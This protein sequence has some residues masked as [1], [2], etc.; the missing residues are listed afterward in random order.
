MAHNH[1]GWALASVT[2]RPGFCH[3]SPCTGPSRVS[4]CLNNAPGPGKVRG[5]RPRTDSPP[6][7]GY[8]VLMPRRRHTPLPIEVWALVAGAFAV[9]LGYGV[10]APAIPQ[11]AHAFGVSNAAASGIVS[12][13]ALMRLVGA[14]LA[15]SLIHISEPTR[16]Y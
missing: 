6:L 13:F 10:V 7:R 5:G 15:L 16:P 4:V 14:P 3:C 11:Y 1:P 8:D 2:G 9:A 12:A